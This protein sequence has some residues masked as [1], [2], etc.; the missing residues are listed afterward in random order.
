MHTLVKPDCVYQEGFLHIAKTRCLLKDEII[1][2]KECE[3][4]KDKIKPKEKEE[5]GRNES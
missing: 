3:T 5:N 2:S 1:D 4:C